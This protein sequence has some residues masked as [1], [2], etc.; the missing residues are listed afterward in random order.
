MAAIAIVDDNDDT[1]EVIRMFLEQEH[2]FTEFNDAQSFLKHLEQSD[3]LIDL[4]LLDIKLP[5]MDGATLVKIVRQQLRMR[6]PIVAI[7]AHVVKDIRGTLL[8]AGFDD[9]LTKPFDFVNMP[10]VIRQQLARG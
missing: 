4:V 6:F 10:L 7:T 2:H 5:D 8:E 1:R 9:V 3:S